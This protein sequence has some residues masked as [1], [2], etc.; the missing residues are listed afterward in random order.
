M[1]NLLN[2]VNNWLGIGH[3]LEKSWVSESNRYKHA[4]GGFILSL[5]F[6]IGGGICAAGCLEFKDVQWSG[7]WKSWDWLDFLATILGA[8]PGSFIHFCL[9]YLI[10][11]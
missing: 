5:I 4:I 11:S 1:K 2:S 8:I 6:G 10:L 9:I 3:K 7:S